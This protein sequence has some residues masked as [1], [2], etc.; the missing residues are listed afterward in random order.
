MALAS[1]PGWYI[2]RAIKGDMQF[3]ARLSFIN[4]T[5]MQQVRN[6]KVIRQ[7]PNTTFLPWG[8]F[9]VYPASK[10]N[11]MLS[12]H[13]LSMSYPRLWA[14]DVA[15][16][17]QAFGRLWCCPVEGDCCTSGKV[18]TGNAHYRTGPFI[19]LTW[20]SETGEKMLGL[21][22]KLYA[23]WLEHH[24]QRGGTL[25]RSLHVYYACAALTLERR[26]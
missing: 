17:K 5:A 23:C 10:F 3:L 20:K 9:S 12:T 26:S 6:L 15:I 24:S 11:S 25:V 7:A 8:I 14:G 1:K 21:V 13:W 2:G 22:D 18:V 16:Q 4:C 19:P